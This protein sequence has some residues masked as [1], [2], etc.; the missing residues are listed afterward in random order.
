MNQEF[1][2]LVCH[3]SS[4]ERSYCHFP[5]GFLGYGLTTTRGNLSRQPPHSHSIVSGTCKHLKEIPF[6]S[7]GIGFTV[8]YTAEKSRLRAIGSDR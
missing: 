6:F 5:R 4:T 2:A 7:G 3:L 8:R 1:S